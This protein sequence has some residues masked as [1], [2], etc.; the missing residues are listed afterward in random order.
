LPYESKSSART[1]AEH[2]SKSGCRR[3]NAEGLKPDGKLRLNFADRKNSKRKPD[4][5]PRKSTAEKKPK[6]SAA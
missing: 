3:K 6:P 2:C 4:S 1:S 5:E